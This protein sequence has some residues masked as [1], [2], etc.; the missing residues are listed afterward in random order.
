MY[1]KKLTGLRAHVGEHSGMAAQGSNTGRG[2][3]K[4]E[5][6]P[7]ARLRECR[8]FLNSILQNIN[9]LCEAGFCF[10]TATYLRL[11]QNRAQVAVLES[12]QLGRVAQLEDLI[13]ELKTPLE[14][15]RRLDRACKDLLGDCLV[16]STSQVAGSIA[17]VS[18]RLLDLFLVSHVCS[19]MGDLGSLMINNTSIGRKFHI[20]S[21]ASS[22]AELSVPV[23]TGTMAFSRRTLKC[24]NRF[25]CGQQVWVLHSSHMD[26]RDTTELFLSTDPDTFADVWG[27][28][29]KITSQGKP[30]E[31]LRYDLDHGSV[32]P[33]SLISGSG[34]STVKIEPSEE[35]CHWIPN[36]ELE[37]FEKAWTKTAPPQ[38]CHSR[39][40]IGACL[41]SVVPNP[42]DCYCN[43]T[44]VNKGFIDRGHRRQIGSSP[45]RWATE[46]VAIG[47]TIGGGGLGLP[48]F[49]YS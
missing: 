46:S 23:D 10:S 13:N 11:D 39:L 34:E 7:Q 38:I 25:L 48:V 22:I 5:P 14:I 42:K 3:S 37:K 16:P 24:L 27:P 41:H 44:A 36:C 18:L 26:P 17:L 45:V 20:S 4:T 47:T 15:L 40:L 21:R 12:L 35:L 1:K 32:V 29:W 8:N 2:E 30:M 49:Q 43:M 28:M 9:V 6:T 31:I 33:F 19:H